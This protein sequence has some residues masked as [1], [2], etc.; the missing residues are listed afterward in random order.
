[1][2]TSTQEAEVVMALTPDDLREYLLA[3]E[4]PA[5]LVPAAKPTPTAKAAAKALGV[6]EGAI[7][8]S[9]LVNV[10][11]GF[12]LAVAPGD[13]RVDLPRVAALVGGAKKVRMANAQEVEAHTGFLPGGVPPVGHLTP[14]PLLLDS[15]LLYRVEVYAGGGDDRTMLRISPLEILRLTGG[16][17]GSFTAP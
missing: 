7:A 12:V 16:K 1:M 6:P 9:L 2:D 17:T 10:D 4:S 8:K 13:R 15:S 5:E 11:G 3:R 14:L